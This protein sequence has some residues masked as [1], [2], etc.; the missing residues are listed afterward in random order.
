MIL[1]RKKLKRIRD[2]K[3]RRKT[4]DRRNG[5]DRRATDKVSAL[6]KDGVLTTQEACDY[7]IISRPTYMKYITEGKIKAKKIGRGWK[8]YISELERFCLGK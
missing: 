1:S 2:R 7:L 3:D 8:V 6:P 4:T 5:P